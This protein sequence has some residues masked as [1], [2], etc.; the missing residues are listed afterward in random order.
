[1]S[2]VFTAY[3]EFDPETR[4]YVGTIPGLPGAHSQAATLDELQ[5]NLVEVI[6]L[7][8][9]DRKARGESV[10]VEPFVGIQQ[11]AVSG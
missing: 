2:K 11:I 1:M 6:E 8:I 5:K 10:E 4:M 7:I 3:V 9:E